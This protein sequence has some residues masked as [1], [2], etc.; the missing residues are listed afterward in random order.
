M[1]LMEQLMKRFNSS[2]ELVLSLNLIL[3]IN[4]YNGILMFLLI[5]PINRGDHTRTQMWLQNLCTIQ[6][7]CLYI[8]GLYHQ[9]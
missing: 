9:F 3:N 2:Y 7:V 1:I 5:F 6:N 8:L 4:L